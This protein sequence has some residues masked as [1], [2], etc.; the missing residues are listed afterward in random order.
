MNELVHNIKVARAIDPGQYLSG[1]SPV[2]VVIDRQGYESVTLVFLANT[3]T[4]AQTLTV[5]EGDTTSPA[6]TVADDDF[7]GGQTAGDLF[8]AVLAGD[9]NVTKKVGYKGTKR[10][11]KVNCTGAGG[12][13]G[14]FGVVAILG[15]AHHAPV[16]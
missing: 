15:H 3:I 8:K 9:D 16:S 6:S 7:V 5:V 10:Y 12:T 2:S 14:L 11:L 1:T 4:D 13:G